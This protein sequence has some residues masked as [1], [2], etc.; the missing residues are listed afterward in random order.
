M[1]FCGLNVPKD[2]QNANLVQSFLSILYFLQK[3]MLPASVSRQMYLENCRQVSERF[4]W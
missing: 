3:Q 4:S 1:N 2:V